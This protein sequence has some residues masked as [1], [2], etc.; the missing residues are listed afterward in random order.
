MNDKTIKNMCMHL[1]VKI[2]F[3]MATLNDLENSLKIFISN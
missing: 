1:Q 2:L 3:K